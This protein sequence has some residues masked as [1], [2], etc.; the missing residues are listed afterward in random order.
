MVCWLFFIIGNHVPTARMTPALPLAGAS[1]QRGSGCHSRFFLFAQMTMIVGVATGSVSLLFCSF[2]NYLEQ[3]DA[4]EQRKV[5]K[6]AR[7]KR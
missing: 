3:I 7:K 1:I 4:K 5:R 6:A 2:T